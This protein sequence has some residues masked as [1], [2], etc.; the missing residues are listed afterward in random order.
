[1]NGFEPGSSG[2]GVDHSANFTPFGVLFEEF[3]ASSAHKYSLWSIFAEN[4]A[5]V[6]MILFTNSMLLELALT[7]AA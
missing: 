3:C 4:S 6:F 1:M 7:L 5:I 2:V